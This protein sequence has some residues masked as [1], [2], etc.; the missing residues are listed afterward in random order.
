MKI[1]KTPKRFRNWLAKQRFAPELMAEGQQVARCL[2]SIQMNTGK[3]DADKIIPPLQAQFDAFVA[4]C[5]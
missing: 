2:A 1:P 4:K 3:P 5:G